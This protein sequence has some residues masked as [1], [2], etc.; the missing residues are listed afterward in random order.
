MLARGSRK[1]QA[2]I[3]FRQSLVGAAVARRAT[4]CFNSFNQK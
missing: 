2:I 4:T 3:K 1:R